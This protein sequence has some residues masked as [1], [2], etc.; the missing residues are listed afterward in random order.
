MPEPSPTLVDQS[1]LHDVLNRPKPSLNGEAGGDD[2]VVL[3]KGQAGY[4]AS[5]EMVVLVAPS[6]ARAKVVM[7]GSTTG[8]GAEAPPIFTSTST[9]ASSLPSAWSVRGSQGS[10]EGYWSL[11]WSGS[12]SVQR[13]PRTVFTYRPMVTAYFHEQ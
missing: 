11:S 13:G 7:R 5:G 8:G 6:L 12:S 2:L 1:Q 9:F 10:R 4:C 3:V